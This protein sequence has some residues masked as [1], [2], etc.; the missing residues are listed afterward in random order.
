MKK[1]KFVVLFLLLVFAVTAQAEWLTRTSDGDGADTYLSNDTQTW[2]TSNGYPNTN[3][4]GEKGA[5]IR[6]LWNSRMRIAYLRFDISELT[7]P[8]TN[9][10]IGV[11]VTGS[12]RLRTYGVYGL[13]DGFDNWDESTV[14]YNNAPGFGSNPPDPNGQYTIDANLTRVADFAIDGTLKKWQY[15]K[16]SASMDAFIALDTDDLLT[17]AVLFDTANTDGNPDVFFTTKERGTGF[18]PRFIPE[19]ATIALLGLGGLVMLRRKR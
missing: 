12:K 9:A 19:P 10:K 15:S 18:A 5:E 3:H 1:V 6:T 17:F 2:S 8:I 14:T 13:K 11:N 4:G 7:L 16:T